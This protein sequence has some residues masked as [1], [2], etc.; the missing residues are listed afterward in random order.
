[1]DVKS[2]RLTFGLWVCV[3]TYLVVCHS[4]PKT[5]HEWEKRTVATIVSSSLP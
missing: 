3:N 5:Y 1:M 2:V 4:S